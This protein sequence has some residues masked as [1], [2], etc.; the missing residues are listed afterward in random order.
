MMLKRSVKLPLITERNV[1]NVMWKI[2]I[3]IDRAGKYHL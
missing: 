1:K 3:V 2:Q